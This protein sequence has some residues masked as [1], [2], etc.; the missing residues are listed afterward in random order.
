M[1]SRHE[2]WVL[3]RRL[4]QPPRPHGAQP[5]V[6]RAEPLE[7]FYDLVVVVLVAQDAHQFAGHLTRHGLAEFAVVFALVWTPGSTAAST[8]NCTADGTHAAG[9][10]SLWTPAATAWALCG[11]G[12]VV[13]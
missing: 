6:R 10:S 4:W 11:G 2:R 13:L 7:L 1:A 8:T 12:A 5:Q 9:S 3:L